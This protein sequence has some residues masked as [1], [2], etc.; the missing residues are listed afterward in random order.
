MDKVRLGVIGCG[1]MSRIHL[2]TVGGKSEHTAPELLPF[3]RQTEVYGLADVNLAHAEAHRQ[4]YGGE[5]IT[6]DPERI[7]TDPNID[8]VL[9]SAWH[10]HAPFPLRALECGKHVLT[11]DGDD[12]AGVRDIVA[13]VERTGLVLVAFRCRSLGHQDIKRDFQPDNI[14]AR[15]FRLDLPEGLAR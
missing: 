8:A 10:T 11:T 7:F 2:A 5:Y 15:P 4:A 9:I 6:D 12:R 3:A 13:A 1:N 14:I